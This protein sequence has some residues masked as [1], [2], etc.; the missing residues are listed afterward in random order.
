MPKVELSFHTIDWLIASNVAYAPLTNVWFV[1]VWAF[2]IFA[3]L[4]T[5]YLSRY[6]SKK[7]KACRVYLQTGSTPLLLGYPARLPIP[8]SPPARIHPWMGETVQRKTRT[9]F[10]PLV[11][12]RDGPLYY[13]VPDTPWM[14]TPSLMR[15]RRVGWSKSS[16]GKALAPEENERWMA[17]LFRGRLPGAYY[18]VYILDTTQGSTYEV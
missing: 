15:C 6:P 7:K 16:S 11:G 9:C 2:I 14:S 8:V 10:V 1:N 5:Q 13:S 4:T 3:N 18:V 12:S 17:E